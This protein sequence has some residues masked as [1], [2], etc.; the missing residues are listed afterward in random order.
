MKIALKNPDGMFNVPDADLYLNFDNP[1]PVEVNFDSIS[2]ESKNA[3]VLAFTHGLIVCNEDL[4]KMFGKKVP[5]VQVPAEN[6]IQKMK[7]EA[8]LRRKEM[9]KLLQLSAKAV[10]K[11]ISGMP[12]RDIKELK[13]AEGRGKK[14]KSV[15]EVANKELKKHE[16]LIKDSIKADSKIEPKMTS[17]H[18]MSNSKYDVQWEEEGDVEVTFG[19]GVSTLSVK[20]ST[21]NKSDRTKQGLRQMSVLVPNYTGD[22]D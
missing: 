8:D 19:E 12:I 17:K 9:T 7:A 6:K 14:R 4:G 21:S 3:L 1:G 16:N 5:A 22:R 18:D 10:M 2:G 20:P 11:K 13:L 15:I